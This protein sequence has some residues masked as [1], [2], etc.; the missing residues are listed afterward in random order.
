[1]S[2]QDR[3]NKKMIWKKMLEVLDKIF[4]YMQL[5]KNLGEKH[6]RNVEYRSVEQELAKRNQKCCL[7]GSV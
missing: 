4:T 5:E 7:Q 3:P 6:W 1:M 2:S